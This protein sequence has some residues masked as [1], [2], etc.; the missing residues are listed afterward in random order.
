METRCRRGDGGRP[1]GGVD[2]L[3]NRQHFLLHP[4]G[5]AW[6]DAV[7]TQDTPMNPSNEDLANGANWTRVYEAKNVRIVAFKHKL[8]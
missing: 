3:I 6:T 1:A 8:E 2:Y 7:V 5:V 4:R